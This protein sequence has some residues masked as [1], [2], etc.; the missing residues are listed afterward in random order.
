PGAGRD[1]RRAPCRAHRQI[2]AT[3]LGPLARHRGRHLY[4][5][6]PA[7][8]GDDRPRR[9]D[10][11]GTTGRR[12]LGHRNTDEGDRRKTQM[13]VTTEEHRKTQIQIKMTTEEHRKTHVQMTTEE[14][15]K[16]HVRMATEEHGKTQNPRRTRRTED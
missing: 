3:L 5:A 1:S 2:A 15:R 11:C 10:Q 16:T 8:R 4:L 14:H 7:A 9:G 12:G 13:N 6:D